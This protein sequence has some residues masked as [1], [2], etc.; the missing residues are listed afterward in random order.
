[1]GFALD[2][3]SDPRIVRTRALLR[4][5]LF[6]LVRER[7]WEKIRVQDILDRAGISRSAFYAHYENKYD[8]LTSGF[9]EIPIL[10]GSA[11]DG[12]LDLVPFFEHVA[13]AAEMIRPLL[14]QPILSEIADTLHR[15][16]AAAWAEYLD[17]H[18]RDGDWVTSEALAGALAATVKRFVAPKNMEAP[19]E[20][21]ASFQRVVRPLLVE[22]G[23]PLEE[24]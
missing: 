13:H 2:Q 7:R 1:M 20:V 22:L 8:L 5:A 9:P 19:A 23:V 21:A 16:M 6:E 14:A 12:K 4:N 11:D 18:V 24:T 17:G 15:G 10:I 3:G